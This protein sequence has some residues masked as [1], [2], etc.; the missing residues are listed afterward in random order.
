MTRHESHF[1][2]LVPCFSA[3]PRSVNELLAQTVS[4]DA[5]REAVVDGAIRL[6]YRDLHL[7]SLRVAAGFAAAGVVAGDRVVLFVTNRH[8]FMVA[9]LAILYAGGIAVPVN[10]REERDG[11]AFVLEQCGAKAIVF[12]ADL[13]GRLPA[14]DAANVNRYSIGGIAGGASSF[15]ALGTAC[16]PLAGIAQPNED[17]TAVLLYTSG[18]TGRPKGAMLTHFNIVHSVLHYQICMAIRAT[19]RSMLAVPASHVTGLVAIAL[20]MF[21]VGA[22]VIIMREF[23]VRPFLELAARERMTHTLVVP[24]IYN[25]LLRD[26]AFESTDLSRWRIGGYGGAPMPGPT[27]EALA[28]KLPGL[29]LQN[30]YGATETTSPVTVIPAGR[31]AAHL[32][33]VGQVVPCGDVRIMDDEDRE[34]PVGEPGEL[35]I[36]GP[37]IVPGYWDNPAPPSSRSRV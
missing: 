35:W 33:S 1:G 32:A 5:D 19:D 23:K 36:G 26:P 27:I 17:D 16:P 12:D 28:Q 24:A 10:V 13:A 31:Q 25:L 21:L 14:H 29:V 18:T 6:S 2:R 15:E 30:A 34:V 8:E 3:R 20:S 7:A 11:L 37:M 9:F 4:R 22:C